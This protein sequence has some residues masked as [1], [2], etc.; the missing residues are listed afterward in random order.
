MYV[1]Q[2]Y[3]GLSLCGL[4]FCKLWCTSCLS[5]LQHWGLFSC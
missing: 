4:S 3:Q 2:F 1:P 5:I